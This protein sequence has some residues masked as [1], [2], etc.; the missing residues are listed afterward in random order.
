[1]NPRRPAPL[2]AVCALTVLEAAA[3]AGLGVAWLTDVVTGRAQMPGASA[4]LAVFALGVAALLAWGARGLWRGQRWARSLVM[5]WQ[6]LLV[7]LS[8]GWLSSQVTPWAVA[9]LL[10]AV[11]VGVGLLLPSVVAAT[12]PGSPGDA[13]EPRAR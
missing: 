1:M 11:A 6:V 5:A 4:F 3:F 9:V 2:V 12:V 7:V 13:G 10:V 8:I